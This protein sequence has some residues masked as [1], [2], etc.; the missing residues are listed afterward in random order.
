MR[1]WG[2]LGW[3]AVALALSACAQNPNNLSPHYLDRFATAN[4][5]VASFT[6]CHGFNCV[7]RKPV[8]LT[9]DQWRRVTATFKPPAKTAQQERQQIGRAVALVE[10]FVG[11]Q[12]GIAAKQWTHKY[13]LVLPNLGDL[14][15]IDCVDASVNTWTYMTLMERAGLFKFHKVTDLSYAGSFTDPDVR[16]T[17][18]VQEINGGYFA[19]DA[20]LVDHEKPPLIMPLAVW[21]DTWPPDKAKIEYIAAADGPGERAR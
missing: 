5:T 18:V 19:V 12:A 6:V 10:S 2:I 21:L 17:A 16:N 15:Q 9:A 13:M 7:E 14:T 8:S 11:P 3:L 4:P 1:A 20:S